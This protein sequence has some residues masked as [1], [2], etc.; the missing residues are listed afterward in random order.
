MDI[1]TIL[2][3]VTFRDIL[4]RDMLIQAR[5]KFR[6]RGVC[7]KEYIKRTS[8]V[9]GRTSWDFVHSKSINPDVQY[10]FCNEI[11][12][13]EFYNSGW[14]LTKMER[15]RIFISQAGYPLKGMHMVLKAIGIVRRTYPDTKVQIAGPDITYGKDPLARLKRGGYGKYI[16]GLIDKYSLQDSIVFTGNLDA[17][18]MADQFKKAHVFVCPSTIENS[19]NSLGEAQL[20]GTPVIASYVGGVPDMVRDGETVLLY[21]PEEFEMLAH[22]IVRLFENDD[23]ALR[24]SKNGRTESAARHDKHVNAN[25]ML[26]IYKKIAH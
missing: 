11:L 13:H 12:R 6:A 8:H 3:S 16:N 17:G 22:N 26:D 15:H 9:T 1:S 14:D 5:R 10:H 2:R 24:L 25:R 4:R 20:V 19:P 23:L 7:E 21:R 18:Q